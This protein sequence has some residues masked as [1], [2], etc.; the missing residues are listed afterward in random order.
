[1]DSRVEEV[2]EVVTGGVG[3][4]LR[5]DAVEDEHDQYEC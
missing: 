5:G 1:M 2:K 3:D 4:E